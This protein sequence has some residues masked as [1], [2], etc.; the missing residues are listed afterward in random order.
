MS[1]FSLKF[2]LLVGILITQNFEFENMG[3]YSDEQGE[4]FHQDDMDVNMMVDNIWGLIIASA[5][6]LREK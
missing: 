1:I 3:V 5:H 4:R 6:E 2:A